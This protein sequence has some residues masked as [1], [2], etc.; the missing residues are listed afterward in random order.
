[1][2]SPFISSHLLLYRVLAASAAVVFVDVT[3]SF[4]TSFLL[5]LMMMLMVAVV[6]V[7]I[8]KKEW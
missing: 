8:K 4:L 1:M 7:I 3:V 5:L 6:M 2:L